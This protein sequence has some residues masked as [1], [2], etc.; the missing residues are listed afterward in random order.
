[1]TGNTLGEIYRV[2][3]WGESHGEAIGCVIDGCPAGLEVDEDLMRKEMERDVPFSSLSRRFEKNEVKILSGVFEGMTTGTSISLMIENHDVKSST[4]D[5]NKWVPRPGHADLSYRKK[6]GHIDWRGGSRASGRTWIPVVAAG[7]IAKQLCSI[8]GIEFNSKILKLGS[9]DVS[10]K[11]VEEIV[12]R[13]VDDF[14]KD[15]DPTGGSIEVLIK[16]L[17]TGL[18]APMFS[19]FHADIGHAVLNIPGVRSFCLG[20]CDYH[21]EKA[22][23]FVDEIVIERDE[24]KPGS[25]RGSGVLGGITTGED[26]IFRMDIKPT[27]S[28]EMPMRSVDLENMEEVMVSSRG[29]FDVNFVPRVLVIAEALSAIVTLNHMMLSGRI[30][31]DSLIPVDERLRYDIQR[32]V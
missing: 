28:T 13:I 11:N 2:T 16:G 19:R 14:S 7:A 8:N 6:Y 26:I 31:H 12:E 18:G 27:P 30:D 9:Y 20:S 4:Y 22:S 24:V 10:E 29:R 17:P 21:G 32:E 1:M 3:T 15:K 25:N 5:E 23:T